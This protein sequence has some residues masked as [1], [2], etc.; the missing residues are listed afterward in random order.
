M[1]E[2]VL[3]CLLSLL[4]FSD[5]STNLLGSLEDMDVVDSCGLLSFSVCVS[6]GVEGVSFYSLMAPAISFP[7]KIVEEVEQDG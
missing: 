4:P 3:C 2:C 5:L 1:C 7:K 6:A